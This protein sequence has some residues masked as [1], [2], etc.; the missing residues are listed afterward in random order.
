MY[1][2]TIVT[3]NENPKYHSKCLSTFPANL[4]M[5]SK[6]IIR[7]NVAI[8][9]TI[10]LN[11]I[12]IGL[13]ENICGMVMLKKLNTNCVMYNKKIAKVE[14]KIIILN[15]SVHLIKPVL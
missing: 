15:L 5:L 14:L 9:T 11:P 10:M 3:I 13:L 1:I 2:Q 4:S 7:L 8:A 6:S 12:P